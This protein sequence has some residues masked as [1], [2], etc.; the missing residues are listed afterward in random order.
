MFTLILYYLLLPFA[1]AAL[2]IRLIGKYGGNLTPEDISRHCRENPI[3]KK[4]YRT[5]RCGAGNLEP[6]GDFETHDEAV[7]AAFEARALAHTQGL[8]CSF[9]VLNHKAEVLDQFDS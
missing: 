3:A 4:F 9:L 2:V 7:D 5:I 6:L 8:H 1:A